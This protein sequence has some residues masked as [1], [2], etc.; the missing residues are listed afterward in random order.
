MGFQKYRFRELGR[1]TIEPDVDVIISERIPGELISVVKAY[2]VRA[3]GGVK[4]MP[5]KDNKMLLPKNPEALRELAQGLI[6]VADSMPFKQPVKNG[7]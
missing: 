1:V 3:N 7:A 5:D 4:D 6:E 2:R